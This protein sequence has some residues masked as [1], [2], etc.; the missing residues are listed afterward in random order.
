MSNLKE[1]IRAN[2]KLH[3][4]EL[5]LQFYTVADKDSLRGRQNKKRKKS[6]E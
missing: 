1:Q 2:Q 3:A 4:R 6:N 5:N